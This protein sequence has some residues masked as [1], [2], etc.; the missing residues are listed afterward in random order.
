MNEFLCLFLCVIGILEDGSHQP[1][2]V[3]FTF[4]KTLGWDLL[5]LYWTTASGSVFTLCPFVPLT[6]IVPETLVPFLFASADKLKMGR[7]DASKDSELLQEAGETQSR[8][9]ESLEITKIKDLVV[10]R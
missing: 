2:A 4:G 1:P 10:L 6:A 9:L 8:W 3:S 5:S 7:T